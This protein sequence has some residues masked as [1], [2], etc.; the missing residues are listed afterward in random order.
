MEESKRGGFRTNSGRKRNLSGQT[1]LKRIPVEFKAIS[2]TLIAE[3]NEMN[4]NGKNKAKSTS[5]ELSRLIKDLSKVIEHCK[6]K[7]EM[8]MQ[9]KEEEQQYNIFDSSKLKSN[10][11]L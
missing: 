3:L 1:Y 9:T 11:R 7:K 2:D 8:M 10:K 4:T 5:S 6:A